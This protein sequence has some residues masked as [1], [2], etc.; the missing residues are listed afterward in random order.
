MGPMSAITVVVF[1]PKKRSGIG[2]PWPSWGEIGAGGKGS[3]D[4]PRPPKWVVGTKRPR[5]RW[6]HGG[7]RPEAAVLLCTRATTVWCFWKFLNNF[8]K[9]QEI[10]VKFKYV[11]NWVVTR[12]QARFQILSIASI[13]IWS[14]ELNALSLD[15][16]RLVY[17]FHHPY[18]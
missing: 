3:D 11:Q 18:P 10:Q 15:S 16:S 17:Q 8:F 1:L 14:T 2:Q 12:C 13:I 6:W 5:R 9:I 7:R 4:Y